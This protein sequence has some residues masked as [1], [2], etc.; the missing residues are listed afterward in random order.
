MYPLCLLRAVG[1]YMVL[2]R[3]GSF[4]ILRDYKLCRLRRSG[5]DM[6]CEALNCPADLDRSIPCLARLSRDGDSVAIT[7]NTS[8]D[9]M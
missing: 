7:V 8:L 2:R 6:C 1:I 9:S 3:K 5:G 4:S